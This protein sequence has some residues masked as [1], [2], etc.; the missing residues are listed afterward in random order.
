MS[1]LLKSESG[2]LLQ[3]IDRALTYKPSISKYELW[4]RYLLHFAGMF[5]FV[6]FLLMR[7]HQSAIEALQLATQNSQPRAKKLLKGVV[8]RLQMLP[9]ISQLNE[10]KS[11]SE[12]LSPPHWTETFQFISNS[13][14]CICWIVESIRFARK[15]A[16]AYA[17]TQKSNNSKYGIFQQKP[18]LPLKKKSSWVVLMMILK[19]FAVFVIIFTFYISLL[20]QTYFQV[21]MSKLDNEVISMEDYGVFSLPYVLVIYLVTITKASVKSKSVVLGKQAAKFAIWHPLRSRKLVS[22]AVTVLKILKRTIPLID[23]SKKIMERYIKIIKLAKQRRQLALQKKVQRM[24]WKKMDP[25][26]RKLKAVLRLQANFRKQQAIKTVTPLLVKER[27]KKAAKMKKKKVKKLEHEQLDKDQLATQASLLMK[28]KQG[29]TSNNESEQQLARGLELELRL[30]SLRMKRILAIIRP[31]SRFCHMWHSVIFI[32]II[33][34]NVHKFSSTLDMRSYVTGIIGTEY[35]MHGFLMLNVIKLIDVLV[36]FFT[37][38]FNE[39]GEL[40]PEAFIPRW[41]PFTLKSLGNPLTNEMVKAFFTLC[42]S[43]A[44]PGR[45]LRWAIA[46]LIP[47][48]NTSLS[49]LV[50]CWY[51]LVERFNS[52]N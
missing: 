35:V 22:D 42:F 4:W 15:K 50:W 23:I 2:Q 16:Y 3:E 20:P 27:K 18:K 6:S 46:F 25:K 51:G 21:I 39:R 5:D 43:S 49:V 37:G 8:N 32:T 30:N 33:L 45:M 28:M 19:P 29:P 34:E 40:V 26:Q 47:I 24:L 36:D 48:C 14:F 10:L 12:S 52:F 7:R 44:G 41:L 11:E 38:R 31:N 17:S 1:Q 9:L 13:F